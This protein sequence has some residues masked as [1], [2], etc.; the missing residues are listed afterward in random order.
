MNLF[1]KLILLPKGV[2]K[3]RQKGNN[4]AENWGLGLISKSREKGR[5]S[6]CSGY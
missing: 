5:S 3:E 4:V 2:Y 1:F 6:V